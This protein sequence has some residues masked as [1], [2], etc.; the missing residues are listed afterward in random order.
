MN[1]ALADSP[2]E[3][4]TMYARGELAAYLTAEE[5]REQG[6]RPF[7]VTAERAHTVRLLLA[8][9]SNVD[10]RTRLLHEIGHDVAYDILTEVLHRPRRPTPVLVLEPFVVRTA[11]DMLW[12]LRSIQ[13]GLTGLVIT[14]DL[15]VTYPASALQT[16]EGR[17]REHVPD[18]VTKL[19][20]VVDNTDRIQRC[21]S[22][23]GWH[24]GHVRMV[25]DG[26]EVVQ[27]VSQEDTWW[28]PGVAPDARSLTVQRDLRFA[29]SVWSD[30]AARLERVEVDFGH[31]DCTFDFPENWYAGRFFPN[32]PAVL[33]TSST[34]H[35]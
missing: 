5:C 23:S 18:Q 17:A 30:T 16:V 6:I 25:S 35:P 3:L 24:S 28:L 32:D 31:V 34:R 4:L 13:V 22:I 12:T 14:S 2:Q 21:A 19:Y 8:V 1:N 27:C 10:E 26:H 9:A 20:R 15:V 11:Q 29:L 33:R 7:G